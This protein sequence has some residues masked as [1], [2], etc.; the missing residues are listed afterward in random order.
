MGRSID[1]FNLQHKDFS[2]YPAEFLMLFDGNYIDSKYL[3]LSYLPIWM[4]I[5]I[6]LT[7]LIFLFMEIFIF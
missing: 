7:V 1:K 5:T 6:P 4:L 3:P 2:E